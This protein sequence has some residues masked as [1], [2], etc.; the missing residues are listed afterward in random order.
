M[1]AAG[2]RLEHD[3]FPAEVPANVRLGSGSWLYS[4]HAFR[5]FRSEL[6]PGVV[7]GDH[8][9][10]YVGSYFNLGPRGSVEVGDY[11]TIVGAIFATNGRVVVGDHAFLAHEVV[12]AGDAWSTP[13][14]EAPH[15]PIVVG[16][17]A[18]VGARAV[19][20]GGARIGEGAIVA[21]GA[22][23]DFAVPAGA[24]VAGNPARVVRTG[25]GHSAR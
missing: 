4:S 6:D 7:I 3:W 19:L 21:A 20:L 25:A 1:T 2:L 17:T 5:H 8:C 24:T 11:T 13:G 9:G 22:V 23:V 10:V 14:D 16:P 12:V 18:W 15:E